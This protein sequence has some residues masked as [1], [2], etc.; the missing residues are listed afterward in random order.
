MIVLIVQNPTHLS[1]RINSH[2]DQI[3]VTSAVKAAAMMGLMSSGFVENFLSSWQ[4]QPAT[5]F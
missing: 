2:V 3:N 1:I 4:E 5:N